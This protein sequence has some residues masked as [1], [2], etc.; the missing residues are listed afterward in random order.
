MLLD[1]LRAQ[2]VKAVPVAGLDRESAH[3]NAIRDIVARHV[4]GACVRVLDEDVRIP[5]VGASALADLLQ[6]LSVSPSNV[7]L[8]LDF[9]SIRGRQ[10]PEL[11]DCAYQFLSNSP[12]PLEQWR[13]IAL[14]ASAM[15]QSLS[16]VSAT[17][18]DTTVARSEIELW[19]LIRDRVSPRRV[20]DYGDYGIVHPDAVDFDPVKMHPAAAIRYT[21]VDGWLLVRGRSL[22]LDG[23]GQ[24]HALA[25]RLVARPEYMGPAFS[26]GDMQIAM[27]ADGESGSGNLTSWITVGTSHHLAVVAAQS[28]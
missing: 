4:Q 24:F 18:S 26:Y 25:Q 3:V 11:A 1:R 19:S 17:N 13:T 16:E 7:D 22:R 14:S 15:P 8:L 5:T 20:P 10:L 28:L 12:Y 6:V 21:L 23:F 9:R 2:G 27:C